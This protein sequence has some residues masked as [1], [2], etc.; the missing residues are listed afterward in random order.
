[1]KKLTYSILA[2]LGLS[3]AFSLSSYNFSAPTNYKD[4]TSSATKY[5]A[6]LANN[7]CRSSATG[8]IYS[9][10]ELKTWEEEQDQ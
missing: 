10:Y 1:M 8:N 4:L 3:L 5:C 2:C 9:G 6:I 7:D